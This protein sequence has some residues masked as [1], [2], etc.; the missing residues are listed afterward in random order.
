MKKSKAIAIGLLSLSLAACHKKHKHHQDVNYYIS[1]NPNGTAYYSASS[2]FPVYLY[3]YMYMS[4]GRYVYSP[5]VSYHSYY[6][7]SGSS[8]SRSMTTS[9]SHTSVSRGGF[10]SIGSGH[11]GSS[12]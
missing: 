4:N 7:S 12:S 9:G 11:G 3:Y 6:R 8:Y 1:T 2:N 10:G 5:G